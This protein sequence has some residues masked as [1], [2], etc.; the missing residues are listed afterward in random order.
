M[1][2]DGYHASDVTHL[3]AIEAA[4]ESFSHLEKKL[5]GN[6][7]WNCQRMLVAPE[8]GESIFYHASNPRESS[9][10]PAEELR[11][12]WRNLEL[13]GGELLES[14]SLADIFEEY[15]RHCE[16]KFNWLTID[17]FPAADLL[18][19]MEK[20]L[21][22][23]DVIEVRA[24]NSPDEVA[25][26]ISGMRLEGCRQILSEAGFVERIECEE[27]TPGVVRAFFVRDW[28]RL[29]GE[30]EQAAQVMRADL[31]SASEVIDNQTSELGALRQD[32][33][34]LSSK[35]EAQ[36]GK[37]VARDIETRRFAEHQAQIS[38][39]KSEK[40]ELQAEVDSLSSERT[41]WQ[42]IQTSLETQLSRLTAELASTQKTS[43]EVKRTSQ[44]SKEVIKRLES[45]ILESDHRMNLLQQELLMA[46]AQMNFIK[47]LLLDGRES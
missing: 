25:P 11:F 18:R 31:R 2:L 14:K 22:H 34:E 10:I 24:L 3:L 38:T 42:Q 5:Y 12:L 37:E 17:C 43:E 40:D 13:G 26:S 35:L 23:L 20:G 36:S 32:M 15:P 30:M 47:D 29:V 16:W 39:L 6:P 4:Q 45:E 19:G 7:E 28:Q 41:Q 33:C 27:P 9:L 1:D 8:S 21:R 44:E 46:E